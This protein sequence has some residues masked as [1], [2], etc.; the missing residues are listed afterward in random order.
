MLSV[1]V[2]QTRPSHDASYDPAKGPVHYLQV[3]ATTAEAA[4]VLTALAELLASKDRRLLEFLR[5]QG[6]VS[7]VRS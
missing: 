7:H 4:A 1:K 5:V 3:T 2:A 6:E